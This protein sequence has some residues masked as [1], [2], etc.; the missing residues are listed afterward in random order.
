MTASRID[1]S[2]GDEP[3]RTEALFGGAFVAQPCNAPNSAHSK[4]IFA[5]A[6]QSS[7]GR[8]GRGFASPGYRNKC[9]DA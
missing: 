3:R 8:T 2:D 6:K 4:S 1:P 5:F 9:S 7:E